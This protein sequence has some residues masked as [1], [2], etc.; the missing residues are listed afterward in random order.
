MMVLIKELNT[1]NDYLAHYILGS[2]LSFVGHKI[3]FVGDR[4]NNCRRV[5]PIALAS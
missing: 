4:H 5:D 1:L 3:P 2:E